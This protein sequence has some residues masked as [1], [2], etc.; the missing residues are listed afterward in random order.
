MFDPIDRIAL[1]DVP[2]E[3]LR[4]AKQGERVGSAPEMQEV[5][6]RELGYLPIGSH[7][8]GIAALMSH[9]PWWISPELCGL[10]EEARVTMPPHVVHLEDLPQ[11]HGLVFFGQTLSGIV[12]GVAHPSAVGAMGWVGSTDGVAALAWS[13]VRHGEQ[14]VWLEIGSVHWP[15]GTPSDEDA[16]IST[17]EDLH[18]LSCVWALAVEPRITDSRAEHV[19]P[20][21]RRRAA[22]VGR[23]ISTIV[24]IDLRGASQAGSGAGGQRDYS[25][26]WTVRGHWRQQPVG[27]GGQQR[28]PTYIAPYIKGP[29]GKPLVV[30]STVGVLR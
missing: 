15:W 21:A 30:K 29:E 9:D 24:A 7:P 19:Q 11:P 25:H 16:S 14:R 5:F 27:P 26:R 1:R 22:R 8:K 20:A 12:D 23:P 2:A 13:L 4:L 3:R 17:I 28:R 6:Q 10:V 18:R